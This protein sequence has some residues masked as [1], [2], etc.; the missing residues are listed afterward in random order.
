MNGANDREKPV[1]SQFRT[2]RLAHRFLRLLWGKCG[3]HSLSHSKLSPP[4]CFNI[5]GSPR[6]YFT[7]P[8]FSDRCALSKVRKVC[9]SPERERFSGVNIRAIMAYPASHRTD[10]SKGRPPKNSAAA[11]SIRFAIAPWT[12]KAFA[13]CIVALLPFLGGCAARPIGVERVSTQEAYQ[14]VEA[15]I[16]LSGKLSS[17]TRT[18]LHRFDLTKIAEEDPSKALLSLHD[19]ALLAQERGLLY[20]LAELSYLAGN[21]TSADQVSENFYLGSAVYAYLF[22]FGDGEDRPDPFDRRFRFACD[23]YNYSLGRALVDRSRS[24]SVVHLETGKR[25][26]PVGE[27][28]LQ[29]TSP[30][31]EFP[32]DQFEEFLLADAFRVKGLSVRNR[33]P[34]LGAPLIAV[35]HIEQSLRIKRSSPVTAFLRLPSHNLR[36]LGSATKPATLEIHSG[37]TE[38]DLT[39]ADRTVPLEKDLTVARAYTLNQSFGWRAQKLHF[40]LPGAGLPGQMVFTEPYQPGRIPVVLVHG[41]YLSPVEWG[42][43]LNTLYGDPLIRK[44]YQLWLYIYSSSKPLVFSGDE[45]RGILTDTLKKVDPEGRDAALQQMVV[46]GHSQGGLLAKMASVDS[47]D[48]LWRVF[49]ERSFTDINLDKKKRE[50]LQRY[51]FLKPLPFVKRVVFISTPHRGSYRIGGALRRVVRRLVSVPRNVSQTTGDIL[52]GTEGITVPEMFRKSKLTSIDGMSPRNPLLLALAE[53]PVAPTV[54]AHSII[55]IKGKGDPVFESDGVV[56]YQSAH[57]E[58]VESELIVRGPHSCQ[59]MPSTIEEIRRILYAHIADER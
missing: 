6:R 12:I 5:H 48:K 18:I 54:K 44:R 8:A 34:G 39:I 20:A 11:A 24:K 57:V 25:S 31:P 53:I 52:K 13:G 45:F 27:I 10:V 41:T 43:M 37:Y 36:Q 50:T 2:W 19:R 9:S 46:I 55:P 21:K 35:G 58:Y 32:L 42:E 26:L 17:D 51:L 40:F 29:V 38:K 33:T 4:S 28:D 47:G 49:S 16:L 22:L 30:D 7:F 15:N 1:E 56:K 3:C 14:Q 59:A 23:L